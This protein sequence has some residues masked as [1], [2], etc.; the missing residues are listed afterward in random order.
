LTPHV[1][2]WIA[3]L[4]AGE[5]GEVRGFTAISLMSYMLTRGMKAWQAKK[6]VSGGGVL[7]NP[8]VH[9]LSVIHAAFGPPR[10][11]AG[12]CARVF[13]SEVEDSVVAVLKYGS[14]EGRLYA[15]WSI[16]GFARPEHVLTIRTARGILRLTGSL[17]VFTASD[18]SASQIAHQLDFPAE[19]DMAPD[20]AGAGFAAELADLR[21]AAV[22]RRGH[23]R[24][25][26]G[27][28][29]AI[30]LERV[31]FRLYE[32]LKPCDAFT[33]V[34]S[35]ETP[36]QLALET[37]ADINRFLDLRDLPAD[38][39]LRAI[40]RGGPWAGFEINP[41]QAGPWLRHTGERIRVTVP[42]FLVQSRLLLSGR[43]GAVLRQMGIGGALAAGW[44]AAPAVVRDRGASFWAAADGLLAAALTRLPRRFHGAILL[45][46]SLADLAITLRRPDR[47]DRWLAMCRAAQPA[48]AAGFHTHLG[49]EAA[50]VVAVLARSPAAVSIMVSPSSPAKREWINAIRRAAG[51]PID[52]AV[53]VGPGPA[54]VHERA[55]LDP[56]AWTGR[57][58]RRADGVLIH[59]V[60]DAECADELQKDLAAR[61]SSA[62]PGMPM[63]A[64]V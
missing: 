25:A 11:V 20:F 59:A 60:A 51:A 10:E 33:P 43:A 44:K 62:F 63:P 36:R 58:E 64:D 29:K 24:T 23:A 27:L 41:A 55:T 37:P 57:D 53:E 48:S 9:V 40:R 50:Q 61:W 4:R 26:P 6:A 56:G 45:H 1:R 14:Y 12:E 54:V 31:L 49:E 19:Y 2:H 42:D 30:E 7:M 13:S 46:P 17:G 28:A 32:A 39:A 16:E 22:R 35:R 18:G 52:V 21:E 38:P 34:M 3:K 8:G 5:L 15:S 47:I